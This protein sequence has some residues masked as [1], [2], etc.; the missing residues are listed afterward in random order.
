MI[1]RM[2]IRLCM[3]KH[4][5]CTFWVLWVN[6]GTANWRRR[7]ATARARGRTAAVNLPLREVTHLQSIWFNSGW[8]RQSEGRGGKE[9]GRVT[10]QAKGGWGGVEGRWQIG[11]K[12]K[13][14]WMKES[15]LGRWPTASLYGREAA[16]EAEETPSPSLL[17]H[18]LTPL[19]TQRSSSFSH[20]PN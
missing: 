10:L 2:T 12:I 13:G 18:E 11:R 14:D 1:N 9:G 4:C 5:L 15:P 7:Y 8:Q 17:L 3:Y 16:T 19:V 6:Y 20:F